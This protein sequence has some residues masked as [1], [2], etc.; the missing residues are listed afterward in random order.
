MSG[1]LLNVLNMSITGGFIVLVLLIIRLV[2]KNLPKRY[3]YALWLIPALRLLCPVSI[4]SAISAFNLVKPRTVEENRME[5]I[6]P[7]PSAGRPIV[8][9]TPA[10][11]SP[12]PSAPQISVPEAAAAHGAPSLSEIIPWIWFAVA[13]GI[14]LWCVISY[15]RVAVTVK[16][17]EY[18]DG[19]YICKNIRSPFV[20][21]I[22]R[23]KIYLPDGLGESDIN[24]ILAHERAHIRRR[25]YIV[26]LLTV[27]ITALHWFNPLVWL[28][29]R[30]MTS[31]M[32]LSCDELA[33]GQLSAEHKKDYANALLNIS[34]R[35][36]GIS[37][38]GLLNFGETGIKARIKEVL[39]MKKPKVW[40]SVIAV[41]VIIVTGVC[42]LTNAIVNSDSALP[43]SFDGYISF[44]KADIPELHFD[45]TVETEA[46]LNGTAPKILFAKTEAG[47]AEAY[48]LGENVYREPGDSDSVYA[49]S[50]LV[51]ISTDGRTINATYPAPAEFIEAPQEHYKIYTDRNY[52]TAFDMELPI[53]ELSYIAE[54]SDIGA[55]YAVRDGEPRL[56]TGDL[57]DIGGGATEACFGY[58]SLEQ[59]NEPNTLVFNVL[60]SFGV[61]YAFDFDSIRSDEYIG[62]HFT[63]KRVGADVSENQSDSEFEDLINRYIFFEQIYTVDSLSFGSINGPD[64][65]EIG[66]EDGITVNGDYYYPVTQEGYTE[67][68]Q[69][70]GFMRG[71]FTDELAETYL[72]DGHYIEHD[73]KTFSLMAGGG[74]WYASPDYI[75]GTEELDDGRLRLDFYREWDRNEVGEYYTVK[76]ILEDTPDGYRIAEVSQDNVTD[77][78]S[79]DWLAPVNRFVQKEFYFNPDFTGRHDAEDAGESIISEIAHNVTV[80]FRYTNDGE[81]IDAFT[82]GREE[83]VDEIYALD[84]NRLLVYDW[85]LIARDQIYLLN[86]ETGAT[87]PVLPDT[88][89]G[90]S[91]NDYYDITGK[92][93]RIEWVTV[94]R[95]S[96]DGSKILYESNKYAENGRP[97]YR[98]GLWVFDIQSGTEERIA[99]PEEADPDMATASYNWTE[100]GR[101]KF[102]CWD[103]G[104][105]Y[106]L[107]Y[108]YDPATKETTPLTT[109]ESVK[110]ISRNFD[111]QIINVDIPVSWQS[112]TLEDYDLQHVGI[113]LYD[114]EIPA[115]REMYGGKLFI[116]SAA[117]G[118]AQ[119]C[120]EYQETRRDSY[121]VSDY[122]T[123]SGY[124]MKL[125]YRGGIPEYATFDDF[126]DM[127]IF[128]DLDGQDDTDVIFRII[129]SIVI[130]SAGESGAPVS[131][132]Y[133]E[134][135]DML[136]E[137]LEAYEQYTGFGSVELSSDGGA[138][139]RRI[140][141]GKSDGIY[142]EYAYCFTARYQ[143]RERLPRIYAVT[144]NIGNI[145]VY[146]PEDEA[147]EEFYDYLSTAESYEDVPDYAVFTDFYA[148]AEAFNR[149]LN[150]TDS[151]AS[152]DYD[153]EA[154]EEALSLSLW[155]DY[156][157]ASLFLHLQRRDNGFIQFDGGGYIP[158]AEEYDTLEKCEAM[159][160]RAF[161]NDF[162]S[163]ILHNQFGR[164]RVFVEHEGKMYAI[165]GDY[166]G[167]FVCDFPI[168]GAVYDGDG[169]MTVYT[170]ITQN[171]DGDNVDDYIFHLEREDGAWKIASIELPDSYADGSSR[172]EFTA[173]FYYADTGA[174]VEIV[175]ERLEAE[176]QSDYV[177]SF[178]IG[179]ISVDWDETYRLAEMYSGNELALERGWSDEDLDEKF[180][181]IAAE[182]DAEYD[183][184]KTAL[185][186]GHIRQTFGMM[187]HEESDEW[188][189]IDG[190]GQISPAE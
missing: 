39:S 125:C 16:N 62:P 48:L 76:L 68:S 176:A 141:V 24:C 131:Y 60:D 142:T 80:T 89:F 140:K 111:G 130:F 168:R 23:P 29:V 69:L 108:I 22:I 55:F 139:V 66:P 112:Y 19:Y 138:D 34:M 2:F 54:D 4:S 57:S 52:L 36:N 119:S 178:E 98:L 101:V 118:F 132:S 81:F 25:D 97:V 26:K 117:S 91:F 152:V 102:S 155:D 64:D 179:N 79:Y 122:T 87:E 144:S 74:G 146:D 114:G 9:A 8:T 127:C 83:A 173:D 143:N 15:I 56:L 115:Q 185:E 145:Y 85:D 110:N 113:Q 73:G 44:E 151:R 100:D 135:K 20:F 129:D 171:H 182:Y 12:A 147:D 31:D 186:S 38:S 148:Q 133:D 104:G 32:E 154:T 77:Y 136:D 177:L 51:G 170:T 14:V 21:G 153:P 65:M 175:R 137:A 162:C 183:P 6:R 190:V 105:D 160:H 128:F 13:V 75:Y 109:A 67:W 94:P 96:P 161:T 43:D 90:F 181:V 58:T 180:Y 189:I 164:H 63:A 78:D 17:S 172:F 3:S 53:I 49:V 42:L 86:F 184:S 106:F 167:T 18:A 124:K 107:D 93:E 169:R 10:P 70:E 149:F 33:L 1:A 166:S 45:G 92:Y 134:A 156:T 46:F 157:E 103:T 11:A 88:A 159:L 27:P 187:Y 47:D 5:Y 188:E 50:L 123:A 40:V 158:L 163:L 61:E 126:R 41:A 82:D 165:D 120:T 116:A 7:Q 99:R 35:Q 150:D 121:D 95:I 59:G 30:L 174:A 37:F 28:G 72:S 71:L 84:E